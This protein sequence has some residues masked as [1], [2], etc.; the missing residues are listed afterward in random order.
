MTSRL[1]SKDG[2]P[3]GGSSAL[4]T[5]FQ[6][7]FAHSHSSPRLTL[8][9]ITPC[10]HV[11]FR[12]AFVPGTAWMTLGGWPETCRGLLARF[13]SSPAI[14]RGR[15][16]TFGRRRSACPGLAAAPA[17]LPT[18]PERLAPG[19]CFTFDTSIREPSSSRFHCLRLLA[20]RTPLVLADLERRA[21]GS[22]NWDQ[23]KPATCRGR[24][25]RESPTYSASGSAFGVTCLRLQRLASPVSFVVST[26]ET[27]CI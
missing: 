25:I 7:G 9:S 17:G 26:S 21:S 14:L 24:P 22:G 8:V 20:I 18:S 2:E 5:L 4:F 1:T 6:C 11:V 3:D 12:G 10:P 19:R 27:G 15:A 16:A 23:P 13:G